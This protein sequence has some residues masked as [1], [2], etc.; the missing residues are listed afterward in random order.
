MP[1]NGIVG[2]WSYAHD[3]DRLD[4]GAILTLARLIAEEFDL[5][6][7]EPLTLF[8]DHKD[9]SWGEAWQERINT[10]LLETTFFI[11][12]ITPRYFTRPECRRELLEFTAKAKN[13][14]T[15]ELLMPILYAKPMNF[16]IDNPDEAVS[17]IAKTQYE[18][19]QELRL[20]E[21]DSR[22]YRRAVS[23]LARRLLDI[24]SRVAEDQLYREVNERE[25]LR[26]NDGIIELIGRIEELLPEWRGAIMGDKIN[27]AQIDVT[28]HE[29]ALAIEKLRRAHAPASAVAASR[30]RAAKEMLPLI[31]RHQR[32]AHTYLSRSVQLDPDVSALALILSKH[33]ENYDLA[34]SIRSAIDEAVS[35][36]SSQASMEGHAVDTHFSEWQHLGKI[37]QKCIAISKDTTR[38]VREGN[39]IVERWDSELRKPSSQIG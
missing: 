37:F 36:I 30:M 5:L 31:E 19:W 22:E 13:I 32:D 3:D 15:D 28:W 14:G 6:S 1:I 38:A 8:V 4:N 10:A 21:P 9:I 12:I 23:A 29:C 2:F 25:D 20:Q 11:P 18:D 26:D 24:S 16:G 39:D 35:N 34:F 33:P 17:L 27:G 7:G